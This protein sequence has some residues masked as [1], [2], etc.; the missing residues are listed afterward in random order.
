LPVLLALV[1][2]LG[3][4]CF[5]IYD[6]AFNCASPISEEESVLWLGARSALHKDVDERLGCPITL[7]LVDHRSVWRNCTRFDS[8]DEVGDSD[9]QRAEEGRRDC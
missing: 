3:D 2:F 6:T 4:D 7:N 1:L 5:L 9:E 8:I